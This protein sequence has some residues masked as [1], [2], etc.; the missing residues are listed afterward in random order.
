MT[1]SSDTSPAGCVGVGA[2]VVALVA[3]DLL[4]QHGGR[5]RFFTRD[6]N[7][8]T[9]FTD[10]PVQHR[11]RVPHIAQVV[12]PVLLIDHIVFTGHSVSC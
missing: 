12:H 5:A 4:E 2:Q 10:N 8:P 6:L 1:S 3:M 9:G 7:A 11:Q